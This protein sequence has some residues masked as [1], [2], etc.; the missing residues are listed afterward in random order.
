MLE[1][2]SAEE[3]HALDGEVASKMLNE[4]VDVLLR[5]KANINHDID[6]IE[7]HRRA[8]DDLVNVNSLFTIAVFVGL[9]FASPGQ[10]HSLENRSACD[11]DPGMARRLIIFEVISFAF[12]L[13]SSLVAKTLKVQLDINRYKYFRDWQSKLWRG[14][15]LSLSLMASFLGIVFLTL[16]M[17]NVIQIRLGKL[18]CGSVH[19]MEAVAPLCAIVLLA[20]AIYV[21]SS[22]NAIWISMKQVQPKGKTSWTQKSGG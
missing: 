15:M 21:P 4:L 13:L 14:S 17:I 5:W 1:E 18:S 19:A 7:V 11:P 20:L 10:L 2:K 16:S 6:T 12:F 22:V 3:E 8:L 9:S